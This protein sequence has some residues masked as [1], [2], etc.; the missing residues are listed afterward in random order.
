MTRS[1]PQYLNDFLTYCEVEK[2]LTPITTKNYACFLQKF[3]LWLEKNNLK[4]IEPQEL[5]EEHIWKYRIWL[6]RLPNTVRKASRGLHVSTQTRYLI[7]LRVLLGYFHEKNIPSLPTEK[8][9]LPKERRERQIKFLDLDQIEKLLSSPNI[10]IMSELRDK[11]ILETLFST[12]LR[13]AE[14]I[15]LDRKR[16]AGA[17]NKIDFEMSIIGKGSYPRT[18]YFSESSLFWIKKYL[19]ARQDDED[20]LFIRTKGPRDAPVRL[21]SRAIEL[22]VEKY[23]KK[24]GISILATP[25]TIRHS[26][27]TD[28]LTQGVDLRT[29]QEFL[30]HRNIATTQVY[31]H[32]TSKRLRDIHRKFHGGRQLSS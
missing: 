2:G 24:A 23:A 9:K 27:A 19:A 29:V 12:G 5:T 20:A 26:F 18:I 11:A 22:I 28:L 31:T 13:V 21:T 17:K 4:D 32:I 30:G 8:I 15:A 14:L 6:S 25:H 10:K 1:I 16:F 7:A 3:F